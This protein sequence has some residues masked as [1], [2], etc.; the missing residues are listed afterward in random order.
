[1]FYET[2]IANR[3]TLENFYMTFG[4]TS[5]GWLPAPVVYT[6]YD[7]GAAIN[8]ARQLRP[9]ATAM[10]EIGLFLQ[11]VPEI[12]KVD[13]GP[14]GHAERPAIKVYDDVNPDTGTHFYIAMHNPS[15]A[16]TN[17]AFTFP[18]SNRRRQLHGAAVRDA[19]DQRAGR[20]D[21]ARRLRHSDG[22]HL[23]YSTSS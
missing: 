15:N 22:Q 14:G 2:N 10:K 16:T 21:P 7:Y 3:L 5:W 23:V 20:Q 6:S 4:G 17:D 9:K 8:E 1:M 18:I 19:P 12:D 13:P 11:S